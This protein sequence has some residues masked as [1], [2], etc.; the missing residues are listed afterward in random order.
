MRPLGYRMLI[1]TAFLATTSLAPRAEAKKCYPS[2]FCY[3]EGYSVTTP[4]STIVPMMV[5]I[6][7][8]TPAQ[9]GSERF[10]AARMYPLATIVD[11]PTSQYNCH[12]YAWFMYAGGPVRYYWMEDPGSY[13]TDRSYT[14]VTR[15][16]PGASIP[17]TVPDGARVSYESGNHSAVKISASQLESKWGAWPKMRHATGYTPYS[18]VS[19]AYYKR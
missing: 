15:T 6:N 4:R 1:T 9:K 13:M 11:D 19:L 17:G 12:S 10:A 14:F 3:N 7:D 5:A 18:P 2:G 16:S 8:Y